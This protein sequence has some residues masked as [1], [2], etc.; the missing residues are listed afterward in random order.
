[1][2]DLWA[3]LR[4]GP[5]P[6]RRT[7]SIDSPAARLRAALHYHLAD[8][9][10]LRLRWTNMVELAPGVWR[11]NH[12]AHA[13]LRTAKERGIRT[14]LNLRGTDETPAFL[15]E[16]ESCAAL[17]LHFVSVKL[18]ARSAPRRDELLKLF[19]AFR[20]VERPVLMHCKSGADRAGL[21]S[22]LYLLAQGAPLA[23]ARRQLSWRFLHLRW[24]KTGILDHVLD[25]YEAR[26]RQGPIGIE[27]WVRDE[28]S[29][30]A[31]T[32]SFRRW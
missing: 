10:A 25:L 29:R 5:A 21:A 2:R 13:R 30:E 11:S 14:I 18:S 31:A 23:E 15:F 1:M 22:A 6:A 20:T 8:H 26:L 27:E 19:E 28:Y 16:R 12:P 9:A 24:S 3:T 4:G 17:G 7:W 32:A